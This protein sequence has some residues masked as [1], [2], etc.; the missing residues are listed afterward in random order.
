VNA[1]SPAT[2]V[3][4]YLR[5]LQRAISCVTDAVIVVERG[6]YQPADTAHRLVLGDGTPIRLAG[7]AGIGL[8]VGQLY[9][10]VRAAGRRGPWHVEPAAYRYALADA[11]GREVLAYHWHP[12]VTDVTFPHLHISHGAVRA[13]TLERAGLSAAHNALRPDLSGAHLPTR[14]VLLQDVLWLVIAHFGA[15]PRRAD[16]LNVLGAPSRSG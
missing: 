14:S 3:N 8:A 15:R 2:A 16:W 6:G 11:D 13:D 10:I 4:A 12:D 7:Q 9:R 1:G 5:S